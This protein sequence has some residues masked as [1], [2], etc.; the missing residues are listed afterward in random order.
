MGEGAFNFVIVG[1]GPTGVEMA[2]QLAELFRCVLK[3]DYRH[4]DTSK[5]TVTLLEKLPELLM[6]YAKPLRDYTRHALEKR[7][8][9]VRTETTVKRVTA[10]AV[11]L[12][13]GERIATQTLI[14]AAG[15]RASPLADSINS[16]KE[17]SGRL[18]V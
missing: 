4:I 13:N 15:V 10:D 7:G 12:T 16:L 11:H 18:L 2:G 5:A 9:V 6:P 8:V 1:G 3:E 17:K 14:W